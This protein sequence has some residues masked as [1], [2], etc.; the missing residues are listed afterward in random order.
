M[1]R[2]NPLLRGA[3]F[4]TLL[5]SGARISEVLVSIPYFA[6][7]PLQL[8]SPDEPRAQHIIVSIPYFAGRPLQ[9]I[10]IDGSG[11]PH[12]A[13]Q[14]PTSRG[15]LCNPADLGSTDL[16][17]ARFNPLLRGAAFAT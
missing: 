6:G 7:R 11:T 2:F 12:E 9:L 8:R 14:S 16:R 15:G 3:A 10:V 17:G 1:K 13:F 4:A 5:T